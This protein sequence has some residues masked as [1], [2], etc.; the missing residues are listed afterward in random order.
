MMMMLILKTMMLTCRM[1]QDFHPWTTSQG[2]DNSPSLESWKCH[3]HCHHCHHYDG[4]D[5]DDDLDGDDDVDDD[6]DDD[7]L[8]LHG[9][10]AVPPVTPSTVDPGEPDFQ[11]FQSISY[12]NNLQSWSEIFQSVNRNISQLWQKYLTTLMV[13]FHN[14]DQKYFTALMEIFHSLEG[15][16]WNLRAIL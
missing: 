4:D 12:R 5:V 6:D 10:D 7:N 9:K 13:K 16:I 3:C 1:G 2:S 14:L 8:V 11:N 15:N